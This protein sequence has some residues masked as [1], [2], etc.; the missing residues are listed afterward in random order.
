MK[1]EIITRLLKHN[2]IFTGTKSSAYD[3]IRTKQTP[4]VTMITCSDSRVP[5]AVIEQDTINRVFSIENIGNQIET[6]EGSVDYGVLHLKTP[7]LLILGHTE[8]GAIKASQTDFSG[9][10]PGIRKELETLKKNLEKF[11]KEKNIWVMNTE[12]ERYTH[13]AEL[14]IDYQINLALDKYKDQVES[15][16]LVVIGMMMDFTGSYGDT[17]GAVYI[18]NINGQTNPE[19]MAALPQLLDLDGQILSARMKRLVKTPP[20]GVL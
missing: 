19:K 1:E 20:H 11:S 18:T 5:T 9:E 15:G 12:P 13:L 7:V 10:T 17:I 6:A 4:Q 16:K 3:N 14:N 2:E 8:C